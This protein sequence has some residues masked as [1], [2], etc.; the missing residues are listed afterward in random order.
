[1]FY[2]LEY[3]LLNIR[4]WLNIFCLILSLLLFLSTYPRFESLKRKSKTK[5]G[6]NCH[7]KFVMRYAINLA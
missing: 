3:A 6:Q 4:N 1:M 2:K 5:A 7:D